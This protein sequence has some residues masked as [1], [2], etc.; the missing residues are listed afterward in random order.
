MANAELRTP[1]AQS[2]R[3]S[4]SQLRTSNSQLRTS[5]LPTQIQHL[6]NRFGTVL[7]DGF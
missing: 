3:R 4:Y 1:F 6:I 2:L 5:T 7:S